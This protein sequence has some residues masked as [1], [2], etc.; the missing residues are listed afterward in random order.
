MSHHLYNALKVNW[1]AVQTTGS[2]GGTLYSGSLLI[3]SAYSKNAVIGIYDN[4]G[5]SVGAIKNIR[6]YGDNSNSGEP[7]TTLQVDGYHATSVANNLLSITIDHTD[8]ISGQYADGS[9]YRVG[10]G[11]VTSVG[12]GGISAPGYIM[13][14]VSNYG[15][16]L[17]PY[18]NTTISK[19]VVPVWNHIAFQYNNDWETEVTNQTS[20]NFDVSYANPL[21]T[22]TREN[23]LD[24]G[25][26]L[27]YT[28]PGNYNSG[29]GTASYND[30]VNKVN[31][32]VNY[33]RPTTILVSGN[34]IFNNV[35][36]GDVEWYA[37]F[38]SSTYQIQHP[39]LL[40]KRMM[41]LILAIVVI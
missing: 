10:G 27:L 3:G 34:N 41:L 17:K 8:A 28:I 1:P 13:G 39:N 21:Y 38:L 26:S 31:P 18:F 15:A 4:G 24:N 11:Y 16:V 40:F 12:T 32:A 2:L 20:F 14:T 35:T 6:M 33:V 37:A 36:I 25:Q 22:S 19:Y 29:A 30:F 7:T 23:S 9:M 5:L